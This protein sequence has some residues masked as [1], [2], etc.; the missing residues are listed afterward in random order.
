M[1]KDN[2]IVQPSSNNNSPMMV[3]L[4][5]PLY[6]YLYLESIGK[7]AQTKEMIEEA[8]NS[9][10]VADH[11]YKILQLISKKLLT[12]D[13]C[14]VA[15]SKNGLNLE[16]VPKQ[17]CDVEMCLTAVQCDGCALNYVPRELLF[18]DRGYDLCL[19]AVRNDPIGAALSYVPVYYLRGDDG[20]VL[21]EE[22]VKANKYAISCVPERFMTE[23][24]VSMSVR[25][26][27]EILQWLPRKYISRDIC[28]MIVEQ[29]P[30]N[31]RYIHAPDEDLV[32]YALEGNPRAILAIPESSL[33]LN[34]C[35]DA[36]HRDP[37]IPISQFRA[38]IHEALKKYYESQEKAVDYEPISLKTP[39][40]PNESEHALTNT[41]GR[42]VVDLTN[43]NNPTN[44][45]YYVTDIHLEHQL[46]EHPLDIMQLTKAEVR[47]RIK[48]K[49]SELIA[50]VPDTNAILLIGGDVA[51]SIELESIFF[52]E[53][54]SYPVGWRGDIY[55]VLGNHELW[56]GNPTG[57][58]PTRSIDEIIAGY[59][60]SMPFSVKLLENEL[61]V[62]YKGC[63][64]KFL[65]ERTILDMSVDELTEIC[66]NSTFIL[67]G[68]IGFSGLNPTF[69]AKKGLYRATVSTE[70]DISRSNQF[71]LVYEKV[72]SCANNLQVIVVTHTQMENWSKDQYNPQWIYVSGHTH[73]NR[74]FLKDNGITVFSDNQFGYKPVTWHLKGFSID[75]KWF[76][77]FRA[78]SDGIHQITREQYADF[79]RGHGIFMEGLNIPGELYA[80]KRDGTYMFVIKSAKSLC[81]LA[82]GGRR[83]L[84]HDINFYFDNLL[85]YVQGVRN[86][87]EPYQQAL[88]KISEEIKLIGGCGNIHGCIVDI[89][90]YNHMYLNPYDGK[91]TPYYAEDMTHKLVFENIEELLASSPRPPQLPDG[92]PTFLRY[93]SLSKDGRLHLLTTNFDKECV[94]ST[95]PQILLDTLMYKPSR[96][97]KS[98]QYIYDK[99][100]V[101]IWDD[102]VLTIDKTLESQKLLDV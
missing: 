68:G 82:G 101:R 89:D 50:S 80:I 52:E 73:R 43:V 9:F 36:L 66:A 7:R 42:Q 54:T 77:P 18:Q 27:P 11:K 20:E 59:R 23:K 6:W 87:F 39:T 1:A 34:L 60:Q 51:D 58:E 12:R 25:L 62:N 61:V 86:I 30:M 49:I 64:R 55:A 3:N 94:L 35:L 78:Y 85:D 24:L 90:F 65:K 63:N 99:N 10:T 5:D 41:K 40:S 48:R 17:H 96:I 29:D 38:G 2:L 37:T 102:S 100:V 70:E 69:N 26:Y 81:L 74:L 72:L 22:A 15:V 53:L 45:V 76:D 98:I 13:I 33:T 28:F 4:D 92:T 21:C 19:A 97:M 47:E 91:L 46:T 83:K 44:L 56:D 57:I 67:L 75:K 14:S 8:V 79:N 32:S 95:P 16:Y 88:S 31:I 93:S 71:R 84:N